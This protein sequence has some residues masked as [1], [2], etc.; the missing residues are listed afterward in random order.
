MYNNMPSV[1]K[2]CVYSGDDMDMFGDSSSKTLPSDSKLEQNSVKWEYKLTQDSD[3]VGPM[4]TTAM[5]KVRLD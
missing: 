1:G 4:T 3:L 2:L 5:I